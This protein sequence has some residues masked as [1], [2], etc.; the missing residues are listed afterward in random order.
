MALNSHSD[1]KL[2]PHKGLL[3]KVLSVAVFLGMVSVLFL[4]N[5]AQFGFYPVCWFF[6]LT[7]LQCPGCGILRATHQLLHGNI[8]VAFRFNP[9]YV[10]AL[11]LALIGG[12]YWT[13]VVLIQGRKMQV[14]D[15]FQNHPVVCWSAIGL[16]IL[17]G[18]LRNF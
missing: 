4:F 8:E 6:K 5:P 15:P 14:K 11:G 3:F 12:I 2:E 18:I 1:P 10:V 13:L 7:G 17:F 9:F 16:F